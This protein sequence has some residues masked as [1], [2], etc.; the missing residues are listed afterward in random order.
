MTGREEVVSRCGEVAKI[1]RACIEKTIMP[2]IS[3]CPHYIR[4][5][6]TITSEDLAQDC[7]THIIEVCDKFDPERG[8]LST[9]V[10]SIT[11]NYCRRLIYTSMM[12]EGRR[13]PMDHVLSLDMPVLPDEKNSCLS[14]VIMSDVDL[15][16]DCAEQDEARLIR[17]IIDKV[18]TD[19]EK[20]IIKLRYDDD[21]TLDKVGDAVGLTRERVRQMQNRVFRCVRVRMRNMERKKSKNTRDKKVCA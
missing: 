6:P 10:W 11:T 19:R 8:A 17:S 7:L 14:E 2:E 15:E 5:D 9:W 1:V 13:P 18:A 20:L 12:R 16:N 4:Y 3:T 21:M